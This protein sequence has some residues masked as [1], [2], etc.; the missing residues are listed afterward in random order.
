MKSVHSRLVG[1]WGWGWGSGC[2]GENHSRWREVCIQNPG[3]RA[4][5]SR[6]CLEKRGAHMDLEWGWGRQKP[7]QEELEEEGPR[8]IRRS[9]GTSP[10]GLSRTQMGAKFKG[11]HAVGEEL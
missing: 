1:G 7:R 3:R 6:E 10:P 9:G 5:G 11:Q 8:A 4:R 2:R